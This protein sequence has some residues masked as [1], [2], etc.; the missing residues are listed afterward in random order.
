AT[1]E[2][3]IEQVSVTDLQLSLQ[4]RLGQGDGVLLPGRELQYIQPIHLQVLGRHLK[5]PARRTLIKPV[6]YRLAVL[7]WQQLAA[8][9]VA[10][11]RVD[12]HFETVL[13]MFQKII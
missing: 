4:V 8:G 12:D 5:A 1:A 3:A 7:D 2:T 10:S 13:G 6:G 9:T 11:C